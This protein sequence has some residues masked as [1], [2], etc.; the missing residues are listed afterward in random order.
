MKFEKKKKKKK[1]SVFALLHFTEIDTQNVS[2]YTV[3]TVYMNK[4]PISA[5]EMTQYLSSIRM[6]DINCLTKKFC[7]PYF[8]VL[9]DKV[10]IKYLHRSNRF[11]EKN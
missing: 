10:V 1:R 8:Y 5:A 9:Q 6:C 2:G 3:G 11:H 4:L 7:V